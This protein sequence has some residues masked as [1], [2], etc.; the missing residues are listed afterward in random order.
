ML[1]L[2]VAV[3]NVAGGRASETR[4]IVGSGG[5]DWL[6]ASITLSVMGNCPSVVGVPESTPCALRL[7]PMLSGGVSDQAS[8]ATPPVALN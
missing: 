8:G 5:A 4:T 7:R 6:A 2:P 1:I 3:V